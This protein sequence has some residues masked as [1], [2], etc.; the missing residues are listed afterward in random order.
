LVKFE[1]SNSFSGICDSPELVESESVSSTCF[2]GVKESEEE[3]LRVSTTN[4]EPNQ[5]KRE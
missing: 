3:P 4:S 1:A 2:F 5:E